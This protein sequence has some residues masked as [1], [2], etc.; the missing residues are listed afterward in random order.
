MLHGNAAS[1]LLDARLRASQEFRDAPRRALEHALLACVSDVEAGAGA[2]AASAS[3]DV[4]ADAFEAIGNVH[5]AELHRTRAETVR[6]VKKR[7][8]LRGGVS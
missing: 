5:E 3:I 4:V 2:D 7:R 8:R 1:I 6:A